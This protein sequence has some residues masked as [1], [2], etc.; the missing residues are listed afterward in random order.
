[1]RSLDALPRNQRG[2]TIWQLLFLAFVFGFFALF[3]LR[4]VPV[5]LDYISALRNIQEVARKGDFNV[6]DPST[7]TRSLEKKWDIDYIK[8]L[9][10]HD[11][12]VTKTVNG[13]ALTFDY[14]VRQ[15]LFY[16]IDLVMEFQGSVPLG[17]SS[18][19]G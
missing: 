9:D 2:M 7:V 13:P 5:Y 8:Y 17:K 6:E 12:K 10:Y 15:H 14:E 16:N 4:T 18:D 3:A 11:I 19:V 1:M